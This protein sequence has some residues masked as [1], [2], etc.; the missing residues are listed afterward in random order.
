MEKQ[1]QAAN[2]DTWL[3]YTQ[4]VRWEGQSDHLALFKCVSAL[5][6]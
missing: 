3:E 1:S 4:E 6:P 5:L 2:T